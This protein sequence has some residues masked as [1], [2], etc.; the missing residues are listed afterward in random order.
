MQENKNSEHYN[1]MIEAFVDKEEKTLW[2]QNAFSKFNIN[3]V[4]ALKWHWSWWAFGLGFMFL[5]YRKAYIPALVL[6]FLTMSIGMIPFVGIGLMILSG[7][8]STYFIY[9]VFKKN[10]L[11]IEMNIED[12]E[13]QLETMREIGGY[14]QWVVWLY[15]G[16]MTIVF[17]F[18]FMII[19]PLLTH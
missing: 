4:D 6:F 13:T 12:K 1:R 15:V 16:F 8:Y 5:L 14:N 7:G 18:V 2:Y 19:S 10:L 3:G 17:F 11:E 9:K